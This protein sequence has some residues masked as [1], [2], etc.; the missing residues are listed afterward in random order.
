MVEIEWPGTIDDL[1]ADAAA[2]DY[3]VTKRLIR[4]WS[5][6][7]LLD[8]PDPRPANGHGSAP[9]LY[10]AGQRRLFLTLV[11]QR[12][13]N[14]IHPRSLALIPVARWMY[15]ADDWVPTRQA[16]LA[17][18]TWIGGDARPS[19][20]HHAEAVAQAFRDQIDNPK[21]SAEAKDELFNALMEAIWA[22]R[23][24][25]VKQL[26]RLEQAIRN[27]FEA[28]YPRPR[29]VGHPSYPVTAEFLI[30]EIKARLRAW[31]EL[32]VGNVTCDAL[33]RARDIHVF[34]LADYM[35][36]L[37]YLAR[38]S[39]PGTPLYPP[40]TV[41]DMWNNCCHQPADGNRHGD[42]VPGRRTPEPRPVRTG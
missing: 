18:N 32:T 17:L 8:Y 24:L 28:G 12:Q 16:K 42:R 13:K 14:H 29:V 10:T 26:A 11:Q 39:A 21:A 36:W 35:V 31:R 25:H 22:R 9:A 41:S 34:A 40:I 20:Y 6:I 23:K 37:R 3:T 38:A 27:V 15:W 7:G 30:R 19:S 4:N 5:E 2:F 33:I 1:V